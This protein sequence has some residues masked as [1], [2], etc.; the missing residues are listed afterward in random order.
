[1]AS[2]IKE[3][4]LEID[5]VKKISDERNEAFKMMKQSHLDLIN[6]FR[7]LEN[8]NQTGNFALI[9]DLVIGIKAMIENQ[10]QLKIY[11]EPERKLED[12]FIHDTHESFVRVDSAF[13]EIA[14]E[15]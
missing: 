10:G 15:N 3:A 12:L 1:M 5:K 13:R 4:N 8:A 6:R 14:K 7:E 2:L 9:A 11:H